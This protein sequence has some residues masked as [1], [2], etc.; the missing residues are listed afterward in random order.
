[1]AFSP[2]GKRLASASTDNT[3]KVWDAQTGQEPLH[4]KG[5]NGVAA[6]SPDRKWLAGAAEG[7]SV[8]VWNTAAPLSTEDRLNNYIN[9]AA[10]AFA[11]PFT[12]GNAPRTDPR[13]RSPFRTNYDLAISKETKTV[14]RVR[15]QLRVELLNVTNAPSFYSG[16]SVFG[17]PAFGT[18]TTQAGFPRLLQLTLRALW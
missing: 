16:N 6:F 12:F 7:N 10:Y 1:M 8:K 14:R 4:L 2:D 15:T 11:G 9:P 3:V 18:I 17:S 13:I 5:Q